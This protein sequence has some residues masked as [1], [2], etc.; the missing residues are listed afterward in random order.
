MQFFERF[1][2]PDS[3]VL[4][5]SGGTGERRRR[6]IDRLLPRLDDIPELR[7]R[8]LARIGTEQLAEVTFLH[9]P[10]LLERVAEVVGEGGEDALRG[11]LDCWLRALERH[12]QESLDGGETAAISVSGAVG[13][14]SKGEAEALHRLA[15]VFRAIDGEL[16]GG[17]FRMPF[18]DMAGRD[19]GGTHRVDSRG[20]LVTASDADHIVLMF[21]ELDSDEGAVLSPLVDRIREARDRALQEAGAAGIRGSLTGVPALAAD[22]LRIVRRGIRLTS[23]L[24]IFG[25]L[26][27][28]YLAFRSLRHT[29]LTLVPLCAG[30]VITLGIVELLYDG[31]NLITSSFTSVLL[32]LGIDFGVHLLYRY[33]EEQRSG[34][35]GERAMGLALLR[36]GPGVTTGA[37]TTVLAFSSITTTDFT[38]FAELGVITVVGI[39]VMMVCA[40]LLI[41]PLMR[42]GER[43]RTLPAPELPGTRILVTAVGKAPRLVLLAAAVVTAASIGSIW[44]SG[45]GFRG[46]FYD[47]LPEE[48]E[49]YYALQRIERSGGLGPAFANFDTGGVEQARS[50]TNRLRAAP[51]VG[52]VHSVTDLLP[53]LGGDRLGRL[54]RGMALM[55]KELRER[56]RPG[57]AEATDAKSLL[58]VL[59]DLQDAFDEVAFA[60]E[61]AG[62]NAS[63]AREVSASVVALRR[64]V[65]GLGDGG[66]ERLAALERR[67]AEVLRRGLQTAKQ[68]A[69]RGRYAATDLPAVFRERFVSKDGTRLA[70][71]A[72][73][74]GDIWKPE[75]AERFGRA[76]T[77][78]DPGVSGMAVEILPNERMIVDGFKRAAIISAILIALS[79]LLIFRNP[80]DAALS[81]LP[82]LLGSI[83]MLGA[84]KPLGLTFNV[85]NVVALPILIGIGLPAGAHMVHRY[86]ESR[87]EGRQQARLSDLV[88]GTGAAVI[89]ASLTTMVGFGALMTADYRAMQSLGLLLSTGIGLCLLASV[90]VLPA[91]LTLLGRAR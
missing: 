44:P 86:R 38:A 78:I 72:Y 50:L 16:A 81:M 10:G 84:M 89:I 42:I 22:E 70:V 30:I 59:N 25:I 9:K 11:K 69:E 24:S 54:R 48:T 28:L 73:P 32:G 18:G 66:R 27:L 77:A 6:V 80:A 39:S 33:G 8:V 41:P 13:R 55:E 23:L 63:P 67:F 15:D 37:V 2:R 90:L 4:L 56:R 1:G 7:N 17:G 65:S 14:D 60:L 83:W 36:A 87:K 34:R 64:T 75:V 26:L 40:F 82:V 43:G 3:V 88:G 62:R 91:L 46:R 19:G 20:Y 21:P 68:V 12:V 79:T 52:R 74:A 49:S 35:E 31:L 5:L 61:Q 76:V 53:P 58:P 71:Y 29:L 51:E 57:D 45:P 85:A 47:F